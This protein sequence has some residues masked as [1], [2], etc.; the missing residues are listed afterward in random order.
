MLYPVF[1]GIYEGK[2]ENLEV[3]SLEGGDKDEKKQKKK[4]KVRCSNEKDSR[5]F[6]GTGSMRPGN[7]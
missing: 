5:K 3:C 7:G 2:T 4:R 6:I 1:W